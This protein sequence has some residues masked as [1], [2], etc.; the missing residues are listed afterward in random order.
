MV[1][2]RRRI[3]PEYGIYLTQ[4]SSQQAAAATSRDDTGYVYGVW[5]RE[6]SMRQARYGSMGF[7]LAYS[8]CFTHL[9]TMKY[10]TLELT[11]NTFASAHLGNCLCRVGHKK[12]KGGQH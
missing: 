10:L 11:P 2:V 12:Q 9:S 7:D 3:Y 6:G 4:S 8:R 5:S 1:V